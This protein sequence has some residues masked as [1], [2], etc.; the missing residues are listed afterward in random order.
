MHCCISLSGHICLIRSHIDNALTF[1]R[2]GSYLISGY[3]KI[4]AMAESTTPPNSPRVRGHRRSNTIYSPP[5]TATVS[6]PD[7]PVFGHSSAAD[8]VANKAS[9]ENLIGQFGRGNLAYTPPLKMPDKNVPQP[10]PAK[11]ALNSGPDEWLQCALRNQYLPEFVMK[12][13][14]EICKEY[15]MEGEFCSLHYFE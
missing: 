12:K 13:L 14:C 4:K 5:T 3:L 9:L 1:A 15:L 11:L 6:V 8:S 10:G 2:R 7:D